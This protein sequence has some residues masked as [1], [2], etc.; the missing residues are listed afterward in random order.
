VSLPAAPCMDLSAAAFVALA[1]PSTWCK[2][3]AIG[4]ADD[5]CCSLHR[6]RLACVDRAFRRACAAHATTCL[7][8]DT[9]LVVPWNGWERYVGGVER[10]LAQHAAA[11]RT[12][13]VHFEVPRRY[14]VIPGC[15][16]R[17]P[18]AVL[19]HAGDPSGG[20]STCKLRTTHLHDCNCLWHG[21]RCRAWH[22]PWFRVLGPC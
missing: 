22:A 17:V 14:S 15:S 8:R 13:H 7:R 11:L 3:S 21:G 1:L 4:C 18:Y 5:Q 6:A 19:T 10:C 2:V 9:Q 12:V 16:P 20:A